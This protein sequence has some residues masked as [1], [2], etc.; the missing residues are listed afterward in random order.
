MIVFVGCVYWFLV[1]GVCLWVLAYCVRCVVVICEYFVYGWFDGA[2]WVWFT[3]VCWLGGWRCC[4]VVSLV[5]EHAACGVVLVSW[6]LHGL[7]FARLMLYDSCLFW[8]FVLVVG[9]VGDCLWLLVC[10]VV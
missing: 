5:L 10:A 9:W 7:M 4:G 2:L 8:L 6:W 1:F 3:L